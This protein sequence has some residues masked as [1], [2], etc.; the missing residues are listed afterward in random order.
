MCT[1]KKYH[2]QAVF[3]TQE[4]SATNAKLELISIQVSA[5]P[6]FSAALT[7]SMEQHA[8]NVL[9]LSLFS[10]AL[11]AQLLQELSSHPTKD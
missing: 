5:I 9:H 6:T 1:L 11:F 8:I 2:L 4:G 7:T 3:P 10:T